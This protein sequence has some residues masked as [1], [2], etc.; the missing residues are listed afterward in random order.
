MQSQREPRPRDTARPIVGTGNGSGPWLARCGI[1]RRAFEGTGELLSPT[2]S[3][4][5]CAPVRPSASLRKRQ[6]T[7]LALADRLHHHQLQ[8]F[9]AWQRPLRGG[10][11][12]HFGAD[13]EVVALLKGCEHKHRH[14]SEPTCCKRLN[15]C[16]IIR[17]CDESLVPINRRPRVAVIGGFYKLDEEDPAEGLKAREFAVEL[18]RELAEQG[19][20]LV[21]YFSDDKSLE[22]HV[23]KGFVPRVHPSEHENRIDVRYSEGQRGKVKFE[24]QKEKNYK[25]LFKENLFPGA[26]WE[27]AFY[28]SLAE[29]DQVDA[30]LLLAGG[31]ST[32]NA[33]HIAIG[34]GLPLLAIDRFPGSAQI[35]RSELAT[36]DSGY[37][38]AEFSSLR[39]LISWLKQKEANESA[40]I[41]E[42]QGLV[43]RYKRLTS[44]KRATR[45]M[46]V[47]LFALISLLAVGFIVEISP[48]AF[49]PLMFMTLCAA[50]ATGAILRGLVASTQLTLEPRLA[51]L[52]GIAAGFIVG[53]AYLIPQFIGAPQLIEPGA[54]T[55]RS[56]DRI[57]LL[58]VSLIALTA[59]MG[60]DS[61]FRRVIQEADST[62]IATK[63]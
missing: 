36:R 59:G 7:L 19:F 18:G 15:I 6:R 63:K 17:V 13:S 39:D 33:G 44:Q 47:S 40:R 53:A 26:N 54:S 28:R 14:H 50:G 57:L 42:E 29:R 31:A 2:A 52:L 61:I 22:T 23:V 5:A 37:P 27:G 1:W 4:G 25:N 9:T 32:L 46:A 55:I 3:R 56:A 48:D 62:S 12:H 60:F 11:L 58:S 8:L 21:V 20:K 41:A 24:E 30:V 10:H 51:C 43:E 16:K 34:R 35:L 38:S 45:W 49:I